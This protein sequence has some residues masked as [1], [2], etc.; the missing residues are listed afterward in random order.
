M[1]DFTGVIEI[2]IATD[3]KQCVGLLDGFERRA[4]EVDARKEVLGLSRGGVDFAFEAIG[5][6]ATAKQAVGMVRKGGTAVF[7]G[8]VPIGTN[9]E[10]HAA[11]IVLRGKHIL[12]C[13]MGDNQF[14][15]DMPRYVDMYL[16]GRLMLDE[17]ISAHM[18]LEQINDGYE[19]M[20]QR[21]G[22]RTVIDF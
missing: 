4:T 7:V 8:V 3:N 18:P 16:D 19:Q 12:G 21:I 13:M 22:T 1:P 15:V 6:A 9:V 10:L 17:M 5:T 14:R 2:D 11:D 20:R